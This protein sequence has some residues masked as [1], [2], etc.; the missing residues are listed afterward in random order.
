ARPTSP[1]RRLSARP[2]ALG[3]PRPLL[4]P[5]RGRHLVDP[6]RPK[7]PVRG[8]D[9]GPGRQAAAGRGHQVQAERAVV[10]GEEPLHAKPVRDPPDERARAQ[11]SDL[12]GDRYPE[13]AEQPGPYHSAVVLAQGDEHVAGGHSL[14]RTAAD[15][16]VAGGQAGAGR[17]LDGILA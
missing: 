17:V 13:L 12:D 8:A 5:S 11:L 15:V 14:A 7:D 2:R 9:P 6:E 4:D 1:P 3:R 10:V 16:L